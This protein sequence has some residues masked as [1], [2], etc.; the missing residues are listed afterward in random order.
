M[1][2]PEGNNESCSLFLGIGKRKHV[3]Q[4]EIVLC[5]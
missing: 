1:F 3:K 5:Y 4:K 2:L